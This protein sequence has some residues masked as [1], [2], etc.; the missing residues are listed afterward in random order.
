MPSLADTQARFRSALVEGD[1]SAILPMLVGGRDPARRV[2]L[3]YRHY[4][5]SLVTLLLGKFPAVCWL[6]G[7]QFV[8]EAAEDFIRRH[9]PTA[10]CIAEYGAD[11]PEFLAERPGAERVPYLRVFAELEWHLGHISIAVD[12]PALGMDAFAAVPADGLPDLVLALQPGL[13]YLVAPW[14]IDELMKLYL[15]ES[16]PERYVFEPAETRIEVSG[17]RGKFDIRRLDVG[18]FAFR[19]AISN[20]ASIGA[21]AERGL[22]SDAAFDPGQALTMLV[23]DG[24]VTAITPPGN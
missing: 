24:L 12:R 21:A 2:A 7:S 16:A 4:V 1:A 19:F 15:T 3:H 5:K 23:G 17:A 13:H 18:T 20:G 22:D 8:A 11:F 9:P 10:P 14:P 6:M